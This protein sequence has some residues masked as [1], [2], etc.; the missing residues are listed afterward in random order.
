MKKDEIA[1]LTIEESFTAVE[2][3]LEKLRSDELEL[4]DSFQLYKDGMEILK[5]CAGKIE[6]V[7]KQVL[8]LDEEGDTV[9]F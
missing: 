9:A 2:E 6:K 3:T 1:K 4:E 5:A 7:E 8:K